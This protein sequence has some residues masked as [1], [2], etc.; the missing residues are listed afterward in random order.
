MKHVSHLEHE[1]YQAAQ[2]NEMMSDMAERKHQ[3]EL[4]NHF[5]MTRQHAI[6]KLQRIIYYHTKASYSWCCSF[7]ESNHV[8]S[9]SDIVNLSM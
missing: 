7:S 3:N 8:L 9:F 2:G 1:I 4:V 5:Y 6:N